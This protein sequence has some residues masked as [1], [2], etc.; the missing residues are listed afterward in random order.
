MGQE[1]DLFRSLNLKENVRYGTHSILK[2]ADEDSDEGL[3]A[4][5]TA[6]ADARLS[7]V[8]KRL[9]GGWEVRNLH[10]YFVCDLF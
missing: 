5:A 9:K 6:V 4:F 10:V 8:A 3:A 7:G 1:N 2:V